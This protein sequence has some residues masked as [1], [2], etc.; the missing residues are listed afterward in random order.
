VV[1]LP[2]RAHIALQHDVDLNRRTPLSTGNVEEG[3][4]E[5]T[6]G[7]LIMTSTTFEPLFS[8]APSIADHAAGPKAAG[9]A[10]PAKSALWTKL[11]TNLIEARQ[12]Q[13]NAIVARHMAVQDDTTLQSMGWTEAE[14]IALRRR[15]GA[16]VR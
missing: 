10:V 4:N 12:A 16:A 15:L 2:T 14:I 5:K 11:Y 9:Q 6:R 3:S 7:D 8:A 1:K 13:A